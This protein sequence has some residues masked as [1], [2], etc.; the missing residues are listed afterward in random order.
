MAGR[1]PDE[2]PGLP[3]GTKRARIK[4]DLGSALRDYDMS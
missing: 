1:T 4:S 3:M 2:P